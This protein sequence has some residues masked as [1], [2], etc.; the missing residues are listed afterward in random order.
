MWTIRGG[1]CE[2]TLD[3]HVNKVWALTTPP[4]SFYEAQEIADNSELPESRKE[5]NLFFSGGSDGIIFVWKD[6]TKEEEH[7]RLKVIEGNLILE[8]QLQNDINGKRYGEVSLF[9]NHTESTESTEL[10]CLI[11]FIG[12]PEISGA[13]T[14]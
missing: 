9:V 14:F 11:L 3:Q 8:Q 13:R 7:N 4:E 5:K 1:D 10:N 2:V 6:V 12:P